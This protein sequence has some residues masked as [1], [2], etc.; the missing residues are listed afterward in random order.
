MHSTVNHVSVYTQ[1]H[2]GI[3]GM[4]LFKIISKIFLLTCLSDRAVDTQS[5]H[6]NI[7][8]LGRLP[9]DDLPGIS[10]RYVY[11][12]LAVH[13][14]YSS[15]HAKLHQQLVVTGVYIIHHF[16]RIAENFRGRKLSRFS[17]FQNPPRKF[18]PRNFVAGEIQFGGVAVLRA[19][20]VIY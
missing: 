2:I 3:I 7:S 10:P 18:S 4:S 1:L 8:M 13:T 17:R 9:F 11:I 20:A 16:Y 6:E 19:C 12:I 14:G 5:W 15:R